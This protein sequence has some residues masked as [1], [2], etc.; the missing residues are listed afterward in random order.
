MNIQQFSKL[1]AMITKIETK[2]TQYDNACKALDAVDEKIYANGYKTNGELATE[3]CD[4]YE[5]QKRVKRQLDKLY[6][7]FRAM[8]V[9]NE[10][11]NYLAER[12]KYAADKSD[13]AF[14]IRVRWNVLDETRHIEFENH[15]N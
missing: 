7:D 2:R 14:Y 15:E 6:R 12:N 1:T 5:A 10:D 13:K 11:I 4:A 9:S 3:W 8:V